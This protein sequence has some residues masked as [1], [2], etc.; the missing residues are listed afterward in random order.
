MIGSDPDLW[1]TDVER[2]LRRIAV[3]YRVVAIVWTGVLVLSTVLQ[4][5][6][7]PR[8]WVI[9]VAWAA[10][11]AW[12]GVVVSAHFRRPLFLRQPMVMMID[13][14]TAVAALFVPWMAGNTTALEFS[15]GYPLSSVALVVVLSGRA[16]F[17]AGGALL[18]AALVRRVAIF[19]NPSLGNVVSDLM[20]WLF[21]TALM[22]WTAT[23]IRGF[24]EDRRRSQEALTEAL[25]E[26]VRLEERQSVAAHLHDSVLQTLALIQRQPEDTPGVAALAR[27]QERELRAWLYG[28]DAQSGESLRAAVEATC[29][30]VED[31]HRIAIELVA[32]G[33]LDMSDDLDALVRAGREAIVNAAKHAGTDSVTVFVEVADGAARMF[34]RDRGQGYDRDAV[35]DDRRGVRDSIIGRMKRH[36]GTAEIRAP[37]GGGTEVRLEM[38]LRSSP[39]MNPTVGMVRE[40]RGDD[41]TT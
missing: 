23:I 15:A 8:L 3:A 41:A 32:A 35:G 29:A 17:L 34:V 20:V 37:R 2:S 39:A 18:A 26:R 33:D 10:M 14:A 13:V 5:I 7:V 27:T 24:A 22:V 36:G 11:I 12:G 30:E 19:E 28:G 21:P 1:L 38:P 31:Q 40:P 16:G 6:V 25:A 9:L 4:D